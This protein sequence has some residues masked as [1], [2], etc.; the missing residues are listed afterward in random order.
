MVISDR[1][2]VA[3]S[4]T[5]ASQAGA[6]IL[7]HGGSAMDAAIAANAVLGVVEPES[8]GMGG[9]L[10]A[11]YWDAKTGKLTGINASGW[12]PKALTIDVLKAAGQTGMPQEG[13]HSVTVPGCVDGWSK[14]HKRFGR[15]PW[16]QL[17]QPAIYFADH[18]YPVTEIIGEAWR[19]EEGKLARDP[20]AA[21]ILLRNGKAPAVG[22][23]F[24]DPQMAAAYKLLA[25]EGAA[26]FYRGAIAK[27]ILRTS[28]RLG[29]K[30]NGADLSEFDAE[31]VEPLST[32]SHGWK[33]YELPPQGQGIAAACLKWI[34]GIPPRSRP[35]SGRFTPSSRPSWRKATSISGSASWAA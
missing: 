11:I 30:M 23:I 4:Q 27:A 25:A 31:W 16:N 26:A 9:D 22:E 28:D 35:A 1:G 17:F 33:V 29:G 24:R 19:M 7:A 3:T 14:L 8:C 32:D 21:R 18:G 12:A 10:F 13:I 20:N 34:R 2:I 15:L 6:Q 5:L